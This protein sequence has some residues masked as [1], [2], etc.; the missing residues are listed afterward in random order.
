MK[1][2]W[3]LGGAEDT[4]NPN[5]VDSIGDALSLIS[6]TGALTDPAL[7]D[8]VDMFFGDHSFH[9]SVTIN[10][11]DLPGNEH[12]NAAEEEDISYY[13]HCPHSPKKD[14]LV[15][16]WD[17]LEELP[18][19]KESEKSNQEEKKSKRGSVIS[20]RKSSKKKQKEEKELLKESGKDKDSD[21]GSKTSV[22]TSL[23]TVL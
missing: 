4:S 7:T 19:R 8:T 11:E 23:C 20:R 22:S 15:S 21:K 5:D 2:F 3:L 14:R 18:A 17:N 6:H 16:K 1:T 12:I 13:G 9:S 10:A